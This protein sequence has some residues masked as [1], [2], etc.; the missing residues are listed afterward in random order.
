MKQTAQMD[1]IQR[2]MRPGRITQSGFL[3]DDRRLLIEILD[4]DSAEV[5]RLGHTHASIA[6]QMRALRDEGMKGLGEATTV[7]PHFEVR[8]DSVRGSLP[9]PFHH[10]GLFPKTN[11]TVTNTLNGRTITYTDLGIHMIAEHGFYE[12]TGSPFRLE[13]AELVAVLAPAPPAP[14]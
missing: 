11:T 5:R 14:G 3:G 10:E 12:G 8:V 7:P 4:S 1:A 2:D 6:R 13:P 9:C